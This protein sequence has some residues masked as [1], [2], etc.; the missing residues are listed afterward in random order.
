[1]PID[2]DHDVAARLSHVQVGEASHGACREFEDVVVREVTR[3]E[4]VH[5]ILAECFLEHEAVAAMAIED[6]VSG[7]AAELHSGRIGGRLLRSVR[8]NR[9]ELGRPTRPLSLEYP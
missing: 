5:H 6:V 9:G 3:M 1:M 8:R 2:R 7:T 4:K